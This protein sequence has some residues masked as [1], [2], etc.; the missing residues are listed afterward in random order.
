LTSPAFGGPGLNGL[1]PSSSFPTAVWIYKL[2]RLCIW[3]TKLRSID[4]TIITSGRRGRPGASPGDG[5]PRRASIM[6]TLKYIY[7]SNKYF[8]CLILQGD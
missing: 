6:N 1:N 5:S 8:I 3:A 4:K 7:I 2:R